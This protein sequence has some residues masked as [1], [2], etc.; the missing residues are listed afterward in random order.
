MIRNDDVDLKSLTVSG[1]GYRPALDG[2]R[3]LAVLAVFAYHLDV[4]WLRGGFLGVD[5]FFVLSGYLITGLLLDEHAATGRIDLGRF[6]TRRA[7]RLLPALFVVVG[8]VA[9][10]TS[11]SAVPFELGL[12]R[13]DLLWTLF[14]GANWHFIATGQDYFAQFASASPVLH[15]W[16]LAI[17]EQFY[18]A[19]PLVTL[20]ALRF[21]IGR[22]RAIVAVSIAGI[23]SSVVAMAMLYDPGDPSRAYF[24]TDTRIHELLVGALLAAALRAGVRQPS[25]LAPTVAGGAVLV[26][27]AALVLVPDDSP[28]YY[29]GGSVA[30]A[31]V[32]AALLWAIDAAPGSHV[33]RA[34]AL[35]PAVWIGR[36]SY[37][38][39]LWHW[40]VILAF[41]TAPLL[42][43]A[44]TTIAAASSFYLLERPIRTGRVPL[45]G[46]SARRFAA[47]A[48]VVAALLVATTAWATTPPVGAP[49]IVEEIKGCDSNTICV[50][51]EEAAGAP[52]LGVVGDSIARSLDPAFLRL[53]ERHRWTYVLAAPNGCR[54]DSLLTSYE[55]VTRPQD[56]ACTD[57]VPRLRGEL[58][59]TWHPDLVVALDRWEIIDVVAPDGRV[60][61]SG[62]PEHV[63]LTEGALKD[64]ALEFTSAGSR[65]VLIE[66]LPLLPVGCGKLAT[67][68]DP[69]CP[70]RVDADSVHPPYNDAFR[71]V[72]EEV[73]GVASISI[74]EAICPDGVCVPL[75]N[76][77]I[78]RPDGLHFAESSG[79]WLADVIDAELAKAHSRS[80][81]P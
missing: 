26:V 7:R 37:G 62:S 36:I 52:V 61:K 4:P 5:A 60:A 24:G 50:R 3:A 48:A 54:L 35:S 69:D 46:S 51:R 41:P 70:R 42:A 20:A 16:S 19:W 1:S 25:R 81:P 80:M 14:Y 40:P 75:V 67:A 44:L 76:G 47:A 53:A 74:V 79:P 23:L 10:W 65:L 38:I 64:V 78:A 29:F 9:I 57:L 73:P 39:Y 30:F 11:I 15:T 18:V 22:P 2:I 8:V 71:R 6:W 32:V 31:A 72:A 49:T 17:E 68:D 13:T 27:I 43:I 34:L 77:A 56:R 33:A 59:A 55:G 58:I 21:S 63:V 28:A 45:I 66:L 12:R